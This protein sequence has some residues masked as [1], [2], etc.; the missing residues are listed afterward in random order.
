MTA[1]RYEVKRGRLRDGG[2][3]GSAWWKEITHIR[4]GGELGGRWF[5]EHVSKR[6][7][8]GSDTFFWNDPWVEGVPL[9]ERFGRL[10]DLAGNKLQTAQSSDRWQGQPDPDEGYTVRGAY[11]LLTSQ[12]FATMDEADKLIWHPQVPLKVSIF[13]WRLLSDRL[14]TKTNLVARGILSPAAHLCVTGCGEVES[15]HHLFISCIHM[16]NK[17]ISGVALLFAAH[18]ASLCV[19]YMDGKKSPPISRLN[20]QLPSVVGQDQAFLL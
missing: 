5:G 6:V 19:G 1:A 2:R 15:A 7:G 12:A 8:D 3:R 9:C 10:F 17:W 16:F 14:P 18:L 4:E 11:K 13:A 20:K